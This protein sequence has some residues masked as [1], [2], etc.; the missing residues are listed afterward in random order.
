[1]TLFLSRNQLNTI[2]AHADRAYPDECCGLMLGRLTSEGRFV[3][4]LWAV[5][6][7]WNAEAAQELADDPGFS[8]ARRYWIAPQEML[9]VM[10]GARERNLEI[11]GVYHSHPDNPA[12]PS[13]CDRRLAW[14]QYSYLIV[15][16]PEG[17]ASD[18]QS[19]A[20]DDRHQFQP[21]PICFTTPTRM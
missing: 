4:D 1:M 12:V 16:V 14:A 18:A 3:E 15:S 9:T 11:I 7:S 6:N 8:K 21:E 2:Y 17:I 19:W 13:E 5:E 10:R 20:L